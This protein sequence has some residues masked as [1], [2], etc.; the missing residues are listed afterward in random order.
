[1]DSRET[2]SQLAKSLSTNFNKVR[3]TDLSYR[4]FMIKRNILSL[5]TTAELN[6]Y[7]ILFLQE[8]T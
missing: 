5:F 2:Y 1:M 3:S 4:F 7:V 6:N 8:I